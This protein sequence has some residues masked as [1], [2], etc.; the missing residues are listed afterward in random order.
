MFK[1]F[2][3]SCLVAFL[4]F[5]WTQAAHSQ[6]IND[7]RGITCENEIEIIPLETAKRNLA[8]GDYDEFFSFVGD[9]TASSEGISQNAIAFKKAIPNGFTGCATV[10]T[11]RHSEQ[12]ISELVV[13]ENPTEAPVFLYWM[14]VRLKEDWR[15][16]QYRVTTEFLEISEIWK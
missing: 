14:A 7:D 3:N 8:H 12:L 6:N 2:V 11:E 5:A 13:F 10:L 9:G 1:S 15:I 4:S 16:V